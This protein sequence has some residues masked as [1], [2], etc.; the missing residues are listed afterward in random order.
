MRYLRT[1]TC[2]AV[3]R[4]GSTSVRRVFRLMD[5]DSGV[6]EGKEDEGQ[7]PVSVEKRDTRSRSSFARSIAMRLRYCACAHKINL[8]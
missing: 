7:F 2:S 1:Y 4:D 5:S 8:F 3:D 6:G